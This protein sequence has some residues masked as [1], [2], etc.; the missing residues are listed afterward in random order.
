MSF[1]ENFKQLLTEENKKELIKRLQLKDDR[2]IRNYINGTRKPNI[3]QL[4]IIKQTLQCSYDDLLED[5][6]ED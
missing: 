3:D 5:K 6:S 4:I 1:S 2:T